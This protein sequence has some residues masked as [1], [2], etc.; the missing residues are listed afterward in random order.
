[1]N[2]S[3]SQRAEP[4]W[5]TVAPS[6]EEFLDA[7]KQ[8][9]GRAV[10]WLKRFDPAPYLPSVIEVNTRWLGWDLQ[11]NG[12]FAEY[13]LE[14][15]DLSGQPATCAEATFRAGAEEHDLETAW[16]LDDLIVA[17][18]GRGHQEA[19]AALH[20]FFE[21]NLRQGRAVGG[22]SI[23][24][25]KG[26]EGLCHVARRTAAML[27]P[28][29]QFA[30]HLFVDTCRED[31]GVA[32]AEDRLRADAASDPAI[33]AFVRM[34]DDDLE[35]NRSRSA[36]ENPRAC[37]T[38]DELL[39]VARDRSIPRGQ[40]TLDVSRWGREAFDAEYAA[41]ARELLD[42]D[43]PEVPVVLR[44]AFMVRPD[45]STFR[46]FPLGAEALA[47]R[48][49]DP[50]PEKR[51]IVRMILARNHGE[52]ARRTAVRLLERGDCRDEVLRM[53]GEN[54]FVTDVPL[55][56]KAVF[57]IPHTDEL[58]V[59]D[60]GLDVLAITDE[61]TD[62]AM[63][64]LLRWVYER[65]PCRMC[66]EGAVRN[67]LDVGPLPGEIAFEAVYDASSDTRYMALH[68]CHP[69]SDDGGEDA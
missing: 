3:E 17:W 43:D 46:P 44:R 50:M 25:I 13:T 6:P 14:L 16:H 57:A 61:F 67:L 11:C 22:H 20:G 18:H 8:G 2:P 12:S 28:D 21:S 59:H 15:A 51:S 64:E 27:V 65:T 4:A 24:A 62:S 39:G 33:A 40:R 10:H 45:A 54:L 42:S 55:I 56:E 66:R 5:M 68:G 35:R 9:L 34:M 19:L 1:M 52:V 37:V 60:T 58:Y 30:P 53:F 32:D 23:V 31:G 49:D 69:P 48:V 26:Y 7:A 36:N 38:L 47:E 29:G 41:G 63:S